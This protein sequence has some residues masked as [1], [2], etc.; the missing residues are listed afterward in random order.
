MAD[1]F[2]SPDEFEEPGPVGRSD[3]LDDF[4]HF[5]A[6]AAQRGPERVPSEPEPCYE[7]LPEPIGASGEAGGAGD[8]PFGIRLRWPAES[9][10]G[11][12]A[13]EA[14]DAPSYYE[15]AAGDDGEP[16]ALL[17]AMAGRIEGV[18]GAIATLAMRVDALTATVNAFRSV[19]SDRIAD[20]AD[21]AVRL[22][23]NQAAE[24][25]EYRHG[26]DRLVGEVRRTIGESEESLRRLSLRVDELG[27]GLSLLTDRVGKQLESVDRL[28]SRLADQSEELREELTGVLGVIRADL[29][30]VHKDFGEFRKLRTEL[31]GFA[32]LR[33]DLVAELAEA[34]PDPSVATAALQDDLTALLADLSGDTDLP[35]LLEALTE[36][37]D[38]LK[39]TNRSAARA[40]KPV[41]D[42]KQLESLADAVAE[43]LARS[44]EVVTD[45]PSAPPAVAEAEEP[46]PDAAPERR[47]RCP[48]RRRT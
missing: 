12:P 9:G 45:A 40:Q 46:E 41:L 35:S 29:T 28:G 6:A 38:E 42:A 5:T 16:P 13:A 10:E 39:K 37:R 47:A 36:I 22:S 11:A 43:R 2:D 26:S 14:D 23:R 7:P 3:P 4:S 32:N 17:P 8:D 34:V 30:K 31:S 18:H 25:E 19:L 15:P 21:T 44:F 24:L 33:E 20:Y 1:D 27:S 48:A